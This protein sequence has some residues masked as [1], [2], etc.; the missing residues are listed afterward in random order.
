MLDSPFH[1]IEDHSQEWVQWGIR[2][3]QGMPTSC[4][5]ADPIPADYTACRGHLS[6][7]DT[8]QSKFNIPQRRPGGTYCPNEAGVTSPCS[9]PRMGCPQRTPAG[10]GTSAAAHSTC[11]ARC[12]A[13]EKAI[14]LQRIEQLAEISVCIYVIVQDLN[15]FARNLQDQVETIG[16]LDRLSYV[17]V[18]SHRRCR[19]RSRSLCLVFASTDLSHLLAAMPVRLIHGRMTTYLVM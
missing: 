9:P 6:E 19:R 14:R 10:P 12:E 17:Y 7:A 8:H 3:T 18:P 11:S 5:R 15:R 13:H 1:N 16:E 2:L 4:G